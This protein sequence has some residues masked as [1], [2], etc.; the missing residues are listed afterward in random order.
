MTV[1][2]L[3]R[4]AAGRAPDSVREVL[5]AAGDLPPLAPSSSHGDLHLR[6]LLVPAAP[7]RRHRLGRRLPR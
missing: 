1:E 5:D 3:P 4:V 6:H 2:A 7:L